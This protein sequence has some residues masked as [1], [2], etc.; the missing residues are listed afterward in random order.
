VP[1]FMAYRTGDTSPYTTTVTEV[2]EE[3]NDRKNAMVE[4]SRDDALPEGMTSPRN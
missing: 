1:H 4:W 2:V 3:A